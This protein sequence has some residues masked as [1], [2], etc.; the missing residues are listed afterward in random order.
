MNAFLLPLG[1][2]GDGPPCIRH[3][4]LAI[5]GDRQ[6]LPARVR[7]PHL[8]ARCSMGLIL[9]FRLAPAPRSF[10][11]PDDCLSSGMHVDVLHCDLLLA[12][13]AVS[14]QR[15]QQ[16]CKGPGELVGLGQVFASPFKGLLWQRY[17]YP[18]S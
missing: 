6:G 15:L 18:E 14:V 12:L 10:N 5:A 9:R 3:R 13:A 17:K 2:P 16:G 4:P 8:S 7:A 1:A 11:H